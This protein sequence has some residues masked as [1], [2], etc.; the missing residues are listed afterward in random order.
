MHSGLEVCWEDPLRC[1]WKAAFFLH[2]KGWQIC[3]GCSEHKQRAGRLCA[4][5]LALDTNLAFYYLNLLW[6]KPKSTFPFCLPIIS[7]VLVCLMLQGF[8]MN[9]TPRDVNKGETKTLLQIPCKCTGVLCVSVL[10]LRHKKHNIVACY[11]SQ[12]ADRASGKSVLRDDKLE[13]AFSLLPQLNFG[14]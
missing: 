10:P 4:G 8:T 11:P 13:K 12:L 3:V 2:S 14:G 1:C 5:R 6:T 9:K 7:A